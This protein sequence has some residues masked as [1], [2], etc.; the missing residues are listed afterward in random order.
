MSQ[1]QYETCGKR[2]GN[3]CHA[4]KTFE[5]LKGECWGYDPDPFWKVHYY[6]KVSTTGYEVELPKLKGGVVAV[7]KTRMEVAKEKLTKDEY[8]RLH[9]EG[10]SDRKIFESKDI[11]RDI[12]YTLKREWGLLDRQQPGDLESE[13]AGM[14]SQISAAASYKY[15][16]TADAVEKI[17]G[18]RAA[19]MELDTMYGAASTQI[20]SDMLAGHLITII[21]RVKLFDMEAIK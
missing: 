16:G 7:E 20:V 9:E 15:E 11:D 13:L 4:F 2:E 17:D 8:L 10:M 18:L 12:F 14:A 21:G 5:C 6:Q 1:Q 3:Q 19:L